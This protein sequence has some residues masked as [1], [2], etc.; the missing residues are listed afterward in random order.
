MSPNGKPNLVLE[1]KGRFTNRP[2]KTG[3]RLYD[4]Y[5]VYIPTDVAR[6]SMFPLKPGDPVKITV[7]GQR[8]II[9]KDVRGE[10]H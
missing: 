10:I 2:T 5:Q 1:G 3:K 9:E 8:V 7:E 4:K 6:D